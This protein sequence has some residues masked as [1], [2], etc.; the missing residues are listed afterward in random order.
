M[1]PTTETT[2][3]LTA[4]AIKAAK[5]KLKERGTPDAYIRLGVKGGGCSGFS[6]VIQYE[7]DKPTD[8]DLEF[9]FYGLRVLVDKKSLN[10]LK[11][12]TLDWEKTLIAQGFK[13]IN[14][15]EKSRCG[16]G[17]SFSV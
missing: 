12:T 7:D 5:E 8:K 6:Y 17:S 14:P 15:N 10:Y 1:I 3:T 16:C 13:F 2:I 11:G 9:D 4:A